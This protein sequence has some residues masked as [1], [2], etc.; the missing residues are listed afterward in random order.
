MKASTA[1]D[2]LNQIEHTIEMMHLELDKH[3]KVTARYRA[4]SRKLR[5]QTLQMNQ[6]VDG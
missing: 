1:R 6:A 3:D 4:L 2:L 5:D